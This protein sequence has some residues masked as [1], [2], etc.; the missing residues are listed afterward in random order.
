MRA[1]GVGARAIDVIPGAGM[2][3]GAILQES[4][5]ITI[6]KSTAHQIKLLKHTTCMPKDELHEEK[7]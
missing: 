4:E 1:F 2:L 7:H 5:G 6:S 3:T